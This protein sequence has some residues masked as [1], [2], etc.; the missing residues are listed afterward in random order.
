MTFLR[1]A[2]GIIAIVTALAWLLA[3][4]T[5]YSNTAAVA[6]GFIPDRLSG[7]VL[8]GPAVPAVL[9]PLS[10]TLVHSGILHLGLNLLILVWCGR[11]VERVL[12]S[13]ALIFIYVVSA[14]VAAMA[15]WAVDP[16]AAVPMVGASGAISGIIG[17]FA[18]SF[19]QQKQIVASARLNRL[20]NALWLLAAWV[21]LQLMTGMLAGLQ[22][23]LLATPAH[24]GGFVAGLLMQR[25]L[26]LWRYRNA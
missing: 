5:G 25:P 21:V 18:L 22:G 15:Q 8:L 19:G 2:T 7:M 4:A 1:T 9:T 24:V 12:G 6:A 26:L 17:A 13:G 3:A 14:Y 23:M 11:A 16:N 10:S 20:L